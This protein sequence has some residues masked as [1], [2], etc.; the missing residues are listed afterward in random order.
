MTVPKKGWKIPWDG[1]VKEALRVEPEADRV[2]KMA[3]LELKHLQ[4]QA[5]LL[6]LAAKKLQEIDFKDLLYVKVF[7]VL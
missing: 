7:K 5:P 1:D 6:T 4:Q 3:R 2:E